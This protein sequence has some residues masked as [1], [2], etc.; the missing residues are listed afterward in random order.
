MIVRRRL[1]RP[2]GEYNK[3]STNSLKLSAAAASLLA[4]AVVFAPQTEA[5]ASRDR[6]NLPKE[7]RNFLE[8]GA[9]DLLLKPKPKGRHPKPKD[10]KNYL[11]SYAGQAAIA[12]SA[13]RLNSAR[14]APPAACRPCRSLPLRRSGRARRDRCH[15]AARLRLWNASGARGSLSRSRRGAR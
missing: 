2:I 1:K 6:P 9:Q 7:F 15:W 13:T 3:M 5:R 10:A 12:V 11:G 8:A 4:A 14:E